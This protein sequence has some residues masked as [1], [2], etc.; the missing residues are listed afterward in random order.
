VKQGGSLNLGSLTVRGGES[1]QVSGSSGGGIYNEGGTATLTRVTLAENT[2]SGFG[3][4]IANVLGQLVLKNTTVRDNHA[5]W[6]GG[7]GTSGT[8][9]M[10]G[11]AIR[12]NVAANWGGGL[13]NG[14]ASTLNHV[15]LDGNDSRQLGGGVVTM[16]VNDESGPLRTNFTRVRGNVARTDG[17]GLYA[18]ADETTTLYRNI[19]SRNSANGGP[20]SGGGIANPG[21]SLNLVLHTDG[22]GE[23]KRSRTDRAAQTPFEVNLI[24]SAVFKNTPTNCAPPNSVPRCDAVGS[25]PATNT[26]KPGRS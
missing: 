19:V 5:V 14:G 9:A 16:S 4:G 22:S 25:S 3:G 17:G 10:R 2:S 26:L 12:D 20:T 7:V 11:G 23:E 15:S 24:R 13:A 1:A 6:G 18:G 21:V 8:M